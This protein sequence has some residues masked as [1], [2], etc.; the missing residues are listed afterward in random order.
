MEYTKAS[1]GILKQ[2][3]RLRQSKRLAHAYL[4]V[5]P[6]YVGKSETAFDFAKHIFC[7]NKDQNSSAYFCNE[8][9]SC[10]K[11]KAGHHPDY[12]VLSSDFGEKIKIDQVRALIEQTKFRP[13]MAGEKVFIVKNVENVTLEGGNALL[14]TLEEPSRYNH[15]FLT[16]SIPENVIDTI[17]SRCHQV[18]FQSESNQK[19]EHLLKNVYDVDGHDAHFLSFFAEGCLGRARYLKDQDFI[20]VKNEIIDNFILSPDSD[21]YMK[22]VLSDKQRTKMLLEVL[23]CWIR[24]CILV[25]SSVEDEKIVYLDKIE[26]LKK[27]EASYSFEELRDL[28]EEIINASRLLAD[29]LNIKIPLL[30]IKEKIWAS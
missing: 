24:D 16:S 12:H 26:A 18:Y 14:K 19:L 22:S 15:I 29:N 7:E 17:R 27:F 5:G 3:I 6:A 4:F 11:M 2:L 20:V 23:L 1:D 25:K 28:S 8:C 30:I 21:A 13:F 9:P 10:L